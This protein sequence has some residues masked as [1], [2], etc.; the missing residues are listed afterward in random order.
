MK[1]KLVDEPHYLPWLGFRAAGEWFDSLGHLLAIIAG[2]ADAGATATILNFIARYGLAERPVKALHPEIRPGDADWRDYYGMLN[3][4]GHYHNGG[5]WPFIGGFYVA[6]LV[7][8]E[9]HTEAEAAL[10]RL[11][12]LNEAGGFNEWHHGS[13]GDPMGMRDQAWS[14]GMY[15]YAF[16]CVR[17]RALPWLA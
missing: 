10:V 16:E 11:A 8:T 15:V 13:T 6:A 1:Q 9:R 2:V 12:L 5:I 7:K 14:S 17:R 3:L 4:P